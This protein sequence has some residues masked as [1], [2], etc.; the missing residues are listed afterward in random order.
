M[1]DKNVKTLTLKNLMD[2]FERMRIQN[3]LDDMTDSVIEER[4]LRKLFEAIGYKVSEDQYGEL[5]K[6]VD[7]ENE[8][9]IQLSDLLKELSPYLDSN[10]NKLELIEA[11]RVFD[12]NHSGKI[13]LFDFRLIMKKYA[14]IDDQ[15]LDELVMDIFEIKK[16][17]QLDHQASIDYLKF[18]ERMYT[19]EEIPVPKDPKK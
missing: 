9:M 14:K 4:Y 15:L 8:G 13:T 11:F 6:R 2:Q 5:V 10:G 7:P 18:C 19:I 3:E 12:P 16:L 1:I 17:N